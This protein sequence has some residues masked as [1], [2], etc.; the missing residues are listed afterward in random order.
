[1]R[2][3]FRISVYQIA[4]PVS[5]RIGILLL[6]LICLLNKVSGTVHARLKSTNFER[7]AYRSNIISLVYSR[8]TRMK[9]L[10][11]TFVAIAHSR[12]QRMFPAL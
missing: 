6:L 11:F 4:F 10:S 8:I 2:G 3:Q 1:M 9:F 12:S 7:L 5:I